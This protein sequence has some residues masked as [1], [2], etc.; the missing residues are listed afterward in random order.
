MI[1]YEQYRL[2]KAGKKELRDRIE[3]ISKGKVDGTGFDILS[4]NNNGTDRFV[5]VKIL[6][7]SS[8]VSWNMKSVGNRLL[9]LLL[10]DLKLLFLL[11]KALP[12]QNQALLFLLLS[13]KYGFVYCG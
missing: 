7:H 10:P 5:E 3:W 12:G 1:A 2:R 13:R 8:E 11:H 4:K 6:S 9:F